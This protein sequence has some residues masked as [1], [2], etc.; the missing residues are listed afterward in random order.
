M[1]LNHTPKHRAPGRL[2]TLLVMAI[3]LAYT[4]FFT[5]LSIL[6]HDRFLT[7]GYDLG[8]FDQTLWN[9]LHGRVLWLTNV[10]EPNS[11]L[12]VHFEPILIPL[13]LSYLVWSDARTLLVIQTIALALGAIPIYWLGRERL[14]DWP[15]LGLVAAYLLFPALEGANLF[16]FHPNTLAVPFLAFAYYYLH[17]RRYRPFAA[18]AILAM[19]CREE[20]S[21]MIGMMGLYALLI[22]R[23]REGWLVLLGGSGMFFLAYFV[24]IP[25]FNNNFSAEAS[26]Y[27]AR[28]AALGNSPVQV[29]LTLITRPGYVLEYLLSNPDKVRYLTHLTAPVA[30]LSVLGIPG[31]LPAVPVVALN[32]LSDWSPNYALDRFHYSAPIVPFVVFAAING[33]KRLTEWLNHWRNISPRFTL[34]VLVVATMLTS[35]GYH[36][37]FGH[38]PLSTEFALPAAETRHATAHEMFRLIPTDAPLSAQ[39]NLNPHLSQRPAMYLF[40]KLDDPT[41]VPAEYVAL[42]RFG[43]IF[44]LTPERFDSML[45]E[46]LSSGEYLVVFDKDG[47]LLLRHR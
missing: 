29:A 1:I 13:S 11:R 43:N 20:I 2:A 24:L 38:T 37:R 6:Q 17:H 28:Y 35:L 7:G 25:Y 42:D 44:P 10:P 8:I 40:P 3:I 9:T 47:Y 34:T 22:H 31:L 19:S 4:A 15:A 27:I 32:L 12:G 14:G 41:A 33:M 26:P 36:L 46:M 23:D 39:S 18:Y 30:F 5:W 21:L 16:E 45:K